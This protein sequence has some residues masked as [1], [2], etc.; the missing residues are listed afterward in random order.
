MKTLCMRDNQGRFLSWDYGPLRT[1]FY[2]K[3]IIGDSKDCWIWKGAMSG[4]AYGTLKVKGR[5]LRANRVAYEL[6]HGPIPGGL[7]VRHTCDNPACVNP[8]HLI[9]GTPKQNTADMLLRGRNAKNDYRAAQRKGAATRR[10]K[11]MEVV[12]P[13]VISQI[14]VLMDKAIK[15]TVRTCLKIPGYAALWG[16][17]FKHSEIMEMVK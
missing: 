9:L 8:S 11:T 1:R 17:Y 3:V 2:A 7:V 6:E 16:H 15:P 4:N 12:M 5:M 14:K 10:K 13:Y